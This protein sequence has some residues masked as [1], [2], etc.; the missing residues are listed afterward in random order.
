MATQQMLDITTDALLTALVDRGILP[1]G[2]T[3]VSV[4][5]GNVLGVNHI[6]IIITNDTFDD[7]TPVPVSTVDVP[8]AI[9][10]LGL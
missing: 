10:G 3:R 7:V 5:A 6:R 2:T 8:A 1:P 9:E 4:Y